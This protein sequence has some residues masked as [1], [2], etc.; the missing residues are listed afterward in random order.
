MGASVTPLKKYCVPMAMR[1]LL[2][3]WQEGV[4]LEY[5]CDSILYKTPVSRGT[6]D[7]CVDEGYITARRKKNGWARYYTRTAK[8]IK[9]PRPGTK[10]GKEARQNRYIK[11][12]PFPCSLKDHWELVKENPVERLRTVTDQLSND[13]DEPRPYY[14]YSYRS[15][16]KLAFPSIPTSTAL[17]RWRDI[18]LDIFQGKIATG[19]DIADSSITKGRYLDNEIR[20]WLTTGESMNLLLSLMM[21]DPIFENDKFVRFN[22]LSVE[23]AQTKIAYLLEDGGNVLARY[24]RYINLI[25]EV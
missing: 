13:K 3:T 4:E 15:S 21:L 1:A 6:F 7:R 24:R 11:T 14:D 25:K 9:P 20:A 2:T 16:Y 17:N 19:G 12:S 8:T 18:L 23:D 5:S 22:K 10:I